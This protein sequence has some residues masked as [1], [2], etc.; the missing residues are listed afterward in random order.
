LE[1]GVDHPPPI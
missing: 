1:H